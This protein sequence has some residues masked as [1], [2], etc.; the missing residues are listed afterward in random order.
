LPDDSVIVGLF[1]G[2]GLL[3]HTAKQLN[4]KAKVVY[5]DFDNYTERLNR[6]DQ[7]NE[8]ISKLHK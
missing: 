3:S 8:L 5:N 1:G 6:I 4:P 2:L 7:T